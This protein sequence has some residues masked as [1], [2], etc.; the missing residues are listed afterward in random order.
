MI[1]TK[2]TKEPNVTKEFAEIYGTPFHSESDEEI[3]G[4]KKAKKQKKQNIT[5][6]V[7]DLFGTPFPKERGKL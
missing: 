5:K 7:A 6:E 3:L 1:M 2:K 4:T